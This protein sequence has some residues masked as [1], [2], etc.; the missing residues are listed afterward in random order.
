MSKAPIFSAKNIP[1]SQNTGNLP[2]M[3]SALEGWMQPMVFGT[4]TKTMINSVVREVMTT[5]EFQGVMQPFSF[6]QLAIK[7]EG[8]RSWKWY[9]LHAQIGLQLE[10]DSVVNYQDVQYR[11]MEKGDYKEYGYVEYHLIQDF[12]G[13]G[14]TDAT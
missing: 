8:E 3:A 6:E 5:I 10:T 4:V 1:L 2:N 9:M 11:V 13:S 14:P 12:T 7:P